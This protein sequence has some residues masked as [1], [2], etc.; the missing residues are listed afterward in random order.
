VR[1]SFIEN[2][3]RLQIDFNMGRLK[4]QLFSTK[5]WSPRRKNQKIFQ[6]VAPSGAIFFVSEPYVKGR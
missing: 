3:N 1:P 6:T 5:Q 2:L 4:Y